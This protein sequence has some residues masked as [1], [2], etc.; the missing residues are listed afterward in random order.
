MAIQILRKYLLVITFCFYYSW[1]QISKFEI[2]EYHPVSDEI[3][4]LDFKPTKFNW[5][6]G[7]RFLLFDEVKNQILEVDKTGE[8]TFPSGFNTN[9]I[10]GQFVWMGVIPEGIGVVDRLQNTIH[11]LDFRLNL[12]STIKFE[13]KLYPEMVT[14]S[15]W[16]KFYFYSKAY[17]SI[18]SFD[19][20]LHNAMPFVDLSKERIPNNCFMDMVLNKDGDL[21]ILS[22]SGTIYFFSMNGK[23]EVSAPVEIDDPKYIISIKNDWLVFNDDGNVFS[24]ETGMKYKVPEVSM[25]ILDI[26]SN[27]NSIAILSLNQIFVLDVK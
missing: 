12:T 23:F 8:L 7:N 1:G 2:K 18:Y 27:N 22:C 6:I 21:A 16:G 17:N 11:F 15:S 3:S 9:S 25:P 5:S 19:R 4:S 13:P 10:Y 20:S 26:K 14:I 24:M